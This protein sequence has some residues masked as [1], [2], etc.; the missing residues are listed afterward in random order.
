[1][2]IHIGGNIALLEKDIVA[3]LDVDS[4]LESEDSQFFINTLI[5]SNRLINNL[6]KDIKSYIITVNNNIDSRDKTQRYNLYTSNISS[7]SLLNRIN[8]NKLDWGEIYV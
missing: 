4:A 3:I 8:K 6:E 7:T 5:K 1:M 2:I